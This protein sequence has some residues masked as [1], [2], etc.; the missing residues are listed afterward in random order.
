MPASAVVRL[1][2]EELFWYPPGRGDEPVS[3]REEQQQLQL[4]DILQARKLPVIFAAPGAEVRL[5]QVQFNASE[6]RHIARSLPYLLE[7]E[8]ASD[9]EQLHI[10]SRAISSNTLAVTCCE[11]DCM[12]D[13]RD[14][15]ADLPGISQWTPEPLLLP[16]QLGEVTVV[17]EAQQALVRTGY[18]EGFAVER[19]LLPVMLGALD[20]AQVDRLI[21]YGLDQPGDEALIPNAFK[22]RQQWR[23]GSFSAALL[24]AEDAD[25]ALNLLQGEYGPKLPLKHWLNDWRWP[26]TWLATAFLLQMLFTYADYAA[27]KQQNLALRQSLESSYRQVVPQGVIADP[28]RQLERKLEELRGG[29]HY[30]LVSLLAVVGQVVQAEKGAQI[31]SINFSGRSGD[32]RFGI[33]LPDFKAVERVRSHLHKAGLEAVVENSNAQGD[34]VR[35]RMKVRAN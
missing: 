10:A 22:D 23:N 30:A 6:K 35:A 1:M 31:S 5:Q 21:V 29:A 32:L 33:L 2:G 26:L 7:D 8:F 16:W 12:Q 28:E 11:H 18:C 24:L 19:E 3:L 17:L 9:I 25:A 27:L 34:A 13:W 20:A 14:H 15:L 4:L